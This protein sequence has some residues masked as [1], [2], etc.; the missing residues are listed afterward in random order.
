MTQSDLPTLRRL[1]GNG[2]LSYSGHAYQRMLDRGISHEDVE[3][4]LTSNTN[5]IIECQSPSCTPGKEHVDERVLIY[6][7]NN[8]VDAIV[9]VSPLFQPAPDVR[10]ITAQKVDDAIWVRQKGKTPCLIRR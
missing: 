5:Q 8:Q 2:V 7:P 4:I 10:V 1:V 6:D 3:D 9:I